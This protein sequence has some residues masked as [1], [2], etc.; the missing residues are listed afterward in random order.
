MGYLQ[1]ILQVPG[2]AMQ[3]MGIFPSFGAIPA[4]R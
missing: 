3:A 1:Q 2:E 4:D